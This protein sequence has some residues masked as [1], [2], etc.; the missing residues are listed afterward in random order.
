[1]APS[2]DR[3]SRDLP[4]LTNPP[5]A[6]ALA[7]FLF[8]SITLQSTAFAQQNAIRDIPPFRFKQMDSPESNPQGLAAQEVAF[9]DPLDPIARRELGPRPAPQNLDGNPD[10]NKTNPTKA[11]NAAFPKSNGG[12]LEAALLGGVSKVDDLDPARKA[13]IQSPAADAVTGNESR[14]RITSDTGNLVGKSLSVRGVS[15]QQ[16]T[17]IVTDTR[18]RGER[19][20]QVLAAG[21]FWAPARMDLDTMMNKIDSR[22]IGSLL[23]IKGPYSPRY[24]PGFSFV[25]IDMLSTPRH[26][27]GFEAHG[28]S[29]VDYQSNGAQWYGRQTFS[30]GDDTWGFRASYG[31]RA[32][33]D[34]T[35]GDGSLIPS[36]YKSGDL[37]LAFGKNFTPDDRLEFNYLRLD[38]SDVEFPGLV[39]DLDYLVT[40]GYELK[41]TGTNPVISD[42][43]TAE[44]WYNRTRFAGNTFNPS[45]QAQIPQLQQLL[46]SP[47]GVDGKA[48]TDGDGMS[49][50]YRSE[51]TFGILGIDHLAFGTD[52]IL[53]EQ[54][55][56]D[57][58]IL[59]DPTDNNFPLPKSKSTDVGFYTE[60][61]FSP[62][63]WLRL[64]AGARTDII[65]TDSA[66]Q[67][68]GVPDTQSDLKDAEL[69]QNFLLWS[70]YVNSDVTLTE[71]WIAS[72]GYGYGQRPPTLTELYVDNAF[73]GSLQRGL[74]FL[75]GDPL[76]NP[77]RLQQIDLGLRG[78]YDRYHGGVHAYHAWIRD[79]ITYDLTTEPSNEDDGLGTGAAFVNTDLAVLKGIETFGRFQWYDSVAL[80]GTLCYVQ[81][82]DL[83]RDKPSRQGE[84]TRSFVSGLN[85]EPLPGIAPLDSRMGVLFHDNS[86][87]QNWG[88]EFSSRMVARQ[89]RIAAT[90][91]EIETP[92]F[93]TLDVRSYRRFAKRSLLTAGIENLTDRFY[94]EHLDYR[95]GFGVFRPGINFYTGIELNY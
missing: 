72:L 66:D 64:N 84:A 42:L 25:D 7:A 44:V 2:I 77:E 43:L 74:T 13:R 23:I 1:M 36:S 19:V 15:N 67:V 65:H 90:L 29:S 18:I 60:K 53:Q 20:G 58:E 8:V 75:E 83:S 32:G 89:S 91:E 88:V 6:Y 21:S 5:T 81:G 79:F 59:A 16:R 24:G 51:A 69:A 12:E 56:N 17:P 87:Q 9:Q 62:L 80:F 28:T 33:N 73:I 30:G 55:L 45:K 63:D 52:L 3:V 92:G 41:Y 34:Y 93:M 27:N 49:F 57:V 94:R 70:T 76:L 95:S 11:Q 26:E 82:D 37:N 86:P 50:G 46:Y 78:S 48:V 40:D 47:S 31:H 39:Y 10:S 71:N 85:K 54:G 38:Q 68:D 61:I 22:L 14:S 35:T 4:I